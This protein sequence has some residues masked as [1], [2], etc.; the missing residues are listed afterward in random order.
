[1][2]GEVGAA[3]AT[4]LPSR[5]EHE[6]I[7]D[8]LA[9]IG[10]QLGE[11]LLAVARVEDIRLVHLDPR[12]STTLSAQPVA[13]AGELLLSGEKTFARGEPFLFRYD[14][15]RLHGQLHEVRGASSAKAD[16]SHPAD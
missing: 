13:C 14:L 9:L 6:V 8:E 3:L 1:M 15:V 11:G 2:I 12:Q 5:T 10:K 7:D 16:R 4:L